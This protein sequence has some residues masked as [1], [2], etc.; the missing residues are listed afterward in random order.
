ML[1]KHRD[2]KRSLALP[3]P[4]FGAVWA[5]VLLAFWAWPVAADPV[6]GED[7]VD[8][9]AEAARGGA[10]YVPGTEIAPPSSTPLSRE[11]TGLTSPPAGTSGG[12]SLDRA[13]GTSGSVPGLRLGGVKGKVTTDR[14]EPVTDRTDPRFDPNAKAGPSIIRG[15]LGVE[16]GTVRPFV[17]GSATASGLPASAADLGDRTQGAGMEMDLDRKTGTML[18]LK[19]ESGSTGKTDTRA[20]IKFDLKF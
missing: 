12:L 7:A 9:R 17:A 20:R 4:P 6:M 16:S 14:S 5:A 1:T 8:K 10:F 11:D 19:S 13:G 2:A 3:C 15:K 18:E